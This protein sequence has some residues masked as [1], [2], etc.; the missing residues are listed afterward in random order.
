MTPVQ[1]GALARAVAGG[2]SVEQVRPRERVRAALEALDEIEQQVQLEVSG[3]VADSLVW[4]ELE[5]IFDVEF[6][7]ATHQ[8][9]SNLVVPQFSFGVV[10]LES[11]S[12]PALLTAVVRG[13]LVDDREIISGAN[14]AIGA[15]APGSTATFFGHV[16]LTFQGYGALADVPPGDVELMD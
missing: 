16:H 11:E 9:Y 4:S 8:R 14:I 2:L 6:L 7:N 3:T 1:T 10:L 5:V 15:V 12:D 13:W